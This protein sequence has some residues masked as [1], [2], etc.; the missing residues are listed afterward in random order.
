ML[1]LRQ[2]FT[3]KLYGVCLVKNEDDIIAQ[4][5]IYALRHCA[6]I[7]VIDN[8]STDETWDTVQALSG[9]YPQIVPL[10]QTHE[11]FTN[12][13]RGLAYNKYHAELS[14]HDWWL[15]LDADEFLAEDPLPVIQRAR[16]DNADII[17]S[18]QVQFYFTDLDYHDW[19][20][21]Q[22]S[23]DLPIFVRR[24]YYNI[25]WQEPRLFRNDPELPWDIRINKHFPEGLKKVCRRHI[26]NRHYQFRDPE[27]IQKRLSMRFGNPLFPHV[28]H[29]DWQSAIVC[30]RQLNYYKE[31][32]PWRFSASG[33]MYYYR[34][35]LKSLYRAA[36]K[37]LRTA[38]PFG[39]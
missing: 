16:R 34:I 31:G 36:V 25:N 27:Q 15:I 20:D 23:R 11:Q 13:L 21:G 18:W 35:I 26:L 37:K 32:E 28:A 19:L 17:R 12:G 14:N 10:V 5:L 6:K 1:E 30:S 24:R 9:G 8:G 2:M 33:V 4:T 39:V 38:V 3:P 22:D 29:P 7:F